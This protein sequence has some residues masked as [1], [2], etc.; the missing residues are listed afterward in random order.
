MSLLL[1]KDTVGG[2]VKSGLAQFVRFPDIQIVLTDREYQTVQLQWLID[3]IN[4]DDVLTGTYVP[5]VFDCEDFVL[6]LRTRT[7]LY[8]V[9]HQANAPM[10]LG[11][12]FTDIHAFNF[13]IDDDQNLVIVDTTKTKENWYCQKVEQFA[14]FLEIDSGQNTIRIV[15]M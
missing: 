7:S 5:E 11:F 10:A 1:S 9:L 13:C 14:S 8:A 2:I 12:I 3:R 4:F 6:Y 15:V